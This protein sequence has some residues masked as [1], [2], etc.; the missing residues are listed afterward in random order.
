MNEQAQE[1][2]E[3]Q[4]PEVNNNI[5]ETPVTPAEDTPNSDELA[6]ETPDEA[7]NL[8]HQI[9]E[10]KDKYARLM[11]DFDNF[12][13]RSNKERIETIQTAGRDVIVSMLEVLDDAERAEK[14]LAQSTDIE[15]LKEGTQLVF[16]K[17]R[18]KLQQK[19]LKAFESKGE[20]FDVEKHEALTEIMMPG[21]EGKVVDEMEKGYLLNDKLI[22][23]AKVVV[24]KS[25][26]A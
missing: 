4:G 7:T 16:N 14:Q 10:W 3:N 17:L 24:G 15:A 1:H 6:S 22:R 8:Q 19:G 18:N 25:N 26:E 2:Q 5:N 13:K 9:D 12:R 23:H 11:A 20:V 21:M